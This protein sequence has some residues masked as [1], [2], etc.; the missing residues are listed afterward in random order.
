MTCG[1]KAGGQRSNAGN[2]HDGACKG[3]GGGA[4]PTWVVPG[5]SVIVLLTFPLL[6]PRIAHAQCPPAVDGQWLDTVTT[7]AARGKTLQCL[8]HS[9][10]QYCLL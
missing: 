3:R 7:G 6:H 10:D 2:H 1:T 9:Y 5:L 4:L 8:N